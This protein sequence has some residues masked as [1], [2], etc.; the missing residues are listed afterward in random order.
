MRL[1]DPISAVRILM[2]NTQRSMK[3][4]T[5]CRPLDIVKIK[6]MAI[7]SKYKRNPAILVKP[8][9]NVR[10]ITLNFDVK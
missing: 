9:K 4:E 6:A 8:R 1:K 2:F 10:E 7:G 5:P 3:I